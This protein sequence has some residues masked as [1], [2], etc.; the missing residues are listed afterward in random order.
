MPDIADQKDTVQRVRA[1]YPTP[2]GTLHA[3]CLLDIAITIG[4][5]AGL[6]DKPSGTNIELPNGKDVAQDIICFPDGH[7][8][9]CLG[10]A[11]NEARPDWQDKGFVD[12]SRYVA[13][14]A[15]P[16]PSD[17]PDEHGEPTDPNPGPVPTGVF[18]EILTE[19]R[20][21]NAHLG[22]R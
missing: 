17:P 4:Q 18:G 15:Q 5:G 20:R 9:D 21:L 11:E 1:K 8:Y 16:V 12:A 7:I 2:L 22:V 19:L 6:L 10:D 14:S 13:V 3:T